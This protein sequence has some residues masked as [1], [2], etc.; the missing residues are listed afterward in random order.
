MR[1]LGLRRVVEN[2]AGTRHVIRLIGVAADLDSSGDS[3][4][5]ELHP[6]RLVQLRYVSYVSL[7]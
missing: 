3:R 6:K 7:N 2:V 4:A 1:F 5:R